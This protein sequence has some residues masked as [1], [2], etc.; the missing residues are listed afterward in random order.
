VVYVVDTE[1]YETVDTIEVGN[2]PIGIDFHPD[3][4]SIYVAN[5]ASNTLS[6]IG[7]GTHA[8]TD[9]ISVGS[10]PIAFGEFIG[11]GV[12]RELKEDALSRMMAVES[13]IEGGAPGVGDPAEAARDLG[14][15][16]AYA[17]AALEENLWGDDVDPRR[18]DSLDGDKV[19]NHARSAINK[20]FDAIE[21]GGI[22]NAE[23]LTE[24]VLIAEELVR[25]DRVLAAV[26][27]DDAIVGAADPSGL[28][29]AQAKL[30]EG[31]ALLKAASLEE[32]LQTKGNLLCDAIT[33][34]YRA[35]WKAIM[36]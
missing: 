26:A 27:I 29:K 33:E 28:M 5:S 32:D 14:K 4:R 12:P 15:A 13:T 20:I 8:V 35:A 31:D 10:E 6:V 24:L 22:E 7:V 25:A 1:T 17:E 18:L 3:G 23:I 36:K 9:T 16:I 21:F 11:P 30:V 34:G 2:G 19:F